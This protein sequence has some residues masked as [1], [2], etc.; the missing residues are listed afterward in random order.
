MGPVELRLHRP[1]VTGDVQLPDISKQNAN[2]TKGLD[3]NS[4]LALDQHPPL[5][6]KKFE[7]GTRLF[8]RLM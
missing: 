8:T 4:L 7:I 6:S 1:R 5:E 2:F 3:K